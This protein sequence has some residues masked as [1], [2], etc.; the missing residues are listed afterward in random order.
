M[1]ADVVAFDSYVLDPEDRV[2]WRGQDKIVLRPRA[3]A[4]L[5]LLVE[6]A[7]QL[8]PK[9]AFFEHVWAGL[10]VS[11]EVLKVAIHELR[12]ALHDGARTPRFIETVS[13]LGYR[14]VAPIARQSAR[15]RGEPPT[16]Y[17]DGVAFQQ[18]GGGSVDLVYIPGWVWA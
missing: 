16:R 13:R 18:W 12:T 14:F 15:V 8:V 7:G 1:V 11:D 2:L 17:T 3:F 9:T 10:S 5:Q 4:V 6:R